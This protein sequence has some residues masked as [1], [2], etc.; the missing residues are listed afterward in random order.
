LWYHPRRGRFVAFSS[1]QKR[2][3]L[4]GLVFATNR[5]SSLSARLSSS[6]SCAGSRTKMRLTVVPPKA[7]WDSP[8]VS[9]LRGLFFSNVAFDTSVDL[10]DSR[11]SNRDRSAAESEKTV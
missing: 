6:P 5:A 8:S 3:C 1:A 2:I 7:D 10:T 11:K 4:G 9:F